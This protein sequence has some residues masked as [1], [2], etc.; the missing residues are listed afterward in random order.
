MKQLFRFVRIALPSIAFAAAW[1]VALSLH[2]DDDK[3]HCGE[4][5][6]RRPAA[7]VLAEGGKWLFTANRASGSIS[8]I[9][10]VQRR[11]IHE[12]EVGRR[13]VD[14]AI[15]P[16]ERFLLAVDQEGDEL[17]LATR[18]GAGVRVVS[19][20]KV[21]AVPT[22]VVVSADGRRC[23][24]ASLWSRRLLI[25][26]LPSWGAG[27]PPATDAVVHG[28]RA[29]RPPAP[30]ASIG[31][32][33]PAGKL[34]LVPQQERL[35]VAD[36]FGGGLCIVDSQ[37]HRVLATHWLPGHNIRG[38]ALSA[39]GRQ[40]LVS[41]QTLSSRTATNQGNVF[42]GAVMSNVVR[43]LPLEA[44][45]APRPA[46]L[47]LGST[48]LL[49]GP[50]N[51]AGDPAALAVTGAGDVLVALA[52]VGELAIRRAGETPWSRVRVGRRPR[53][54]VCDAGGKL[55]LVAN[56]F[57]DT[58]AVVQ[59]AGG[60]LVAKIPLGASRELSQAER[61][62]ML[63]YDAR[64]SLDGWM[65]C[66][67]CH[68]DGHTAGLLS[69][70]L[71]DGTFGAAKRV[72]SLLGTADTGP[73]AWDG[74]VARLEDQVRKSIET[75]MRGRNV[76]DAQVEALTAYLRSLPPPRV[77][78]ISQ[79]ASETETAELRDLVTRGR[80]AFADRGCVECHAPPAYTSSATY[81]VGLA[82][83]LGQTRFNPP[84]LRG[85]SQRGPFFH[86]NRADSLED[87]FRR[88]GHPSGAKYEPGEV[89][90]LVAFLRSL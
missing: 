53:S 48:Q 46:E 73:W 68:S 50:G 1:F 32:P 63:F 58:I 80:R 19:R 70:T 33:F 37:S 3:D 62:E 40:L 90:A 65:S 17:V 67:S 16:D 76:G 2:A 28:G 89:D 25:V 47:P 26:D 86:D 30:V 78:P 27:V 83:E 85:V 6:L 24:V 64:L 11:S 69:D 88:H 56:E 23:Y 4:A 39:D 9:D 22:S 36:A 74:H 35:I 7:L 51:A 79:P 77:A 21:A 61:G 15:T 31:L 87:V 66:H 71:G 41:H 60:E 5:R 81:D 52:G 84:S 20:I 55:A 10:L 72:P 38:L 29:A 43:A 44:V 54:V 14:L 75:T 57:S 8:A 12:T 82:D 49:G 34:L 45:L 13:L 18:D 42:W 59:V